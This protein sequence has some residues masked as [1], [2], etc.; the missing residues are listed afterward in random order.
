MSNVTL[1]TCYYKIDSKFSHDKYLEWINNFFKLNHVKVVIYVDND[2][3]QILKTFA[4]P[5]IEFRILDISEFEM[6]KY[7]HWTQDLTKDNE[8]KNG[9]QHSTSLYKIWNE[10]AYFLSR[11]AD[12]NPFNTQYFL[13]IDIGSFRDAS[14][15]QEINLYHFP[16]AEQFIPNKVTMFQI[17]P[18]TQKEKDNLDQYDNRFALTCRI[19]GLFGGNK[20][21]I[22]HFKTK[23]TELLKQFIKS[24]AFTGKDQAIYSYICL[25][26]PEL[27]NVIN[28]HQVYP[29]Y[30]PWFCFHYYF[31]DYQ[32]TTPLITVLIPIY[33]GIEFLPECLESLVSQ[34]YQ[35]FNVLIGING[36]PEDSEIYQSVQAYAEITPELNIHVVDLGMCKSI[37]PKA[38]ALN[39]MVNL[40]DE[41][42]QWIALLDVDD[43]WRPDKLQHQ[44]KFTDKYSVIGSMCQYF[45]DMNVVPTL[46]MEDITNFDFTKVNPIINSSC[47]IRKNL[48]Y[49]DIIC[50]EDY[51][52]WLRLRLKSC[53]MYNVPK[54]LVDHRIHQ[55]SA[56]NTKEQL[57]TKLD[58]YQQLKIRTT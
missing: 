55:D 57:Y 13:W 18:F 17:A 8:L 22:S 20:E 45:G 3:Y 39:K 10:K 34:T 53:P 29:K 28:A 12:D 36:H 32:V 54:I 27:V 48:A 52:L 42:C 4:K 44:V 47:L 40:V 23:H 25:K 26:Y 43:C 9:I 38:L 15:L 7:N 41:E 2:S 1:V 46:P 19:G 6:S 11:T 21:A 33:N 14:R 31:S 49:W 56:F 30:D 35:K 24:G 50:I 51:D 16:T 37:N 5:G 58:S